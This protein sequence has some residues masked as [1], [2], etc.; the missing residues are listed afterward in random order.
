MLMSDYIITQDSVEEV[1]Q[2][3]FSVVYDSSQCHIPTRD[4]GINYCVIK[5]SPVVREEDDNDDEEEEVI[6]FTV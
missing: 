1:Q 4:T 3:N 6:T 2:D 5:D